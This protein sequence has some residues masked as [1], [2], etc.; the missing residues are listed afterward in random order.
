MNS[1]PSLNRAADNLGSMQSA[2]FLENYIGLRIS[3][4][5]LLAT[6]QHIDLSTLAEWAGFR[7]PVF[8]RREAFERLT[9]HKSQFCGG[10]S[11]L[12]DALK[13]MHEAMRKF[14]FRDLQNRPVLF[15]VGD[16]TLIAYLGGV[17]HDDPRPAF[18]VV[19]ASRRDD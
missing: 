5:H 7:L 4:T 16:T 9:N 12:F 13:S 11:D 3:R 14:P 1:A 18:T 6:G 15:Q 17:D 8:F 2:E 19:L 10:G